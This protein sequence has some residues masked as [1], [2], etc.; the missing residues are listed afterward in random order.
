MRHH[1][2]AQRSLAGH[3]S[4]GSRR[5]PSPAGCPLDRRQTPLRAGFQWQPPAIADGSIFIRTVDN[6]SC[7]KAEFLTSEKK[8]HLEQH[9]GSTYLEMLDFPAEFNPGEITA[10]FSVLR[11]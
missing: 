11:Q 6:L 5:E 3:S 1:S 8:Y 7:I 4:L 9:E 2:V 10:P